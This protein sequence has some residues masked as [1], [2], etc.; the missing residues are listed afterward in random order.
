MIGGDFG[1]VVQLRAYPVTPDAGA[2]GPRMADWNEAYG[3]FFDFPG[4]PHKPA[5]TSF[6]VTALPGNRT[7]EVEIITVSP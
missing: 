6:P 2:F 7:I 1:S 5:R 3:R 4:N